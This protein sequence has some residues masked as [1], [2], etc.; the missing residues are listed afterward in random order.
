MDDLDDLL[1]DDFDVDESAG[2]NDYDLVPRGWYSARVE[3]AEVKD[4]RGGKA[5]NLGLSIVGPSYEGRWV[6]DSFNVR[7]KSAEAQRI[8][9]EE[10]AK[11]CKSVGLSG[12]PKQLNMLLGKEMDIRVGV[13][14]S[15]DPQYED[16]NTVKSY[17]PLGKKAKSRDGS[18]ER[19]AAR[20][21]A[22]EASFD[23]SFN[24]DDI[25]F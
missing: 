16:K 13:E 22:P 4:T 12:R 17:A 5:I 18:T 15:S 21:K 14:E 6:W 7:N 3:R 23:Q 24:D 2:D 9:H 20:Q 8:A 19:R 10:F 1:P 11:F 25:P